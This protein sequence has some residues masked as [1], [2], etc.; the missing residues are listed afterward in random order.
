MAMASVAF[1]GSA[2]GQTSHFQSNERIAFGVWSGAT[3]NG[4]VVDTRISVVQSPRDGNSV[5]IYLTDSN[6]DGSR[7]VEITAEARSGFSLRIARN[8]SGAHVSGSDL[9]GTRCV[10]VNHEVTGCADITVDVDVTWTGVGP[11]EHI[12]QGGSG[13]HVNH[14]Q[15]D[16]VASGSAAGYALPAEDFV[17]GGLTVSNFGF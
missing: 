13:M 15:R 7:F 14:L 9:P 6:L 4:T 3:S 1:T 10:Y 11:I 5:A 8:L 17:F 12:V 2:S 16:A